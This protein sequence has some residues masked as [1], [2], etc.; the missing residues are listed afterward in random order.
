MAQ[1]APVLKLKVKPPGRAQLQDRRRRKSEDPGVAKL[2]GCHGP[3]G[4]GL[5]PQ[6]LPIPEFPVLEF[7]ERHGIVLSPAGKADAADGHRAFHGLFLILQEMTLG[8]GSMTFRVCSRVEPVGSDH[9]RQ[10]DSLILIGEV[11]GRHALEQEP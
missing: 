5:D 3:A 2:E 11:G 8:P 10:Q 7:D 4:N 1:A 9:L 6:I